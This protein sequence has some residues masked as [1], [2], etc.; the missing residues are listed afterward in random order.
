MCDQIDSKSFSF[1]FF[2]S[3]Q[4]LRKQVAPLLKG[5]Q[6][7][8]SFVPVNRTGWGGGVAA[9]GGGAVAGRG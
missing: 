5:F 8:V 4:D 6:A 3:L 9:V 1:F 2:S 7:E